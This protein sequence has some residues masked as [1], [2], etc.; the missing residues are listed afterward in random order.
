M[1]SGGAALGSPGAQ[2]GDVLIDGFG[3]ESG[4]GAL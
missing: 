2:W 1:Q 4:D 3:V